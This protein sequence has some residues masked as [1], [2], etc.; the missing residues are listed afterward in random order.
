MMAILALT[1]SVMHCFCPDIYVHDISISHAGSVCALIA[2]RWL[3]SKKRS[4]HQIQSVQGLIYNI[5]VPHVDN[6]SVRQA[7]LT[8]L[9]VP[10]IVHLPTESI[11]STTI[12]TLHTHLHPAYRSTTIHT[13]RN[14]VQLHQEGRTS[15]SQHFVQYIYMKSCM[16]RM[17]SCMQ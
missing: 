5:S 10:L 17:P 7:S 6:Q 12:V 14:A 4:H 3:I 13:P 15:I 9:P 2:S 16:Y 11:H 8:L 1:F